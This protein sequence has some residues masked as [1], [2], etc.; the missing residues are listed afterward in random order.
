[1][2]PF[3]G[4][5]HLDSFK[6]RLSETRK[7]ELNPMYGKKKSPE[8]LYHAHKSLFGKLNPQSKAVQLRHIKTGE[9]RQFGA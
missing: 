4:K 2:N 7:G 8:F 6:Q 9:V 1:L 3:Y 5:K